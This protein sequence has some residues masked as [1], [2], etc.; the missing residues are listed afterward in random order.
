MRV[1]GKNQDALETMLEHD[2]FAIIGKAGV[3]ID[4]RN[5]PIGR[6]K[7]WIGRFATPV[8]FGVLDIQTFMHLKTFTAHAAEGAAHPGAS[9]RR[10][11]V[12]FFLAGSEDGA[13]WRGQDENFCRKKK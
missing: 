2:V 8:C 9:R 3:G 13:I 11:E 7:D 5:A 12:L 10:R 4:I 6:G 1:G